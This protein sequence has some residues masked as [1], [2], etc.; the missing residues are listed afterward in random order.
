MIKGTTIKSGE[1]LDLV[2]YDDDL[3]A[4]IDPKIS[5]WGEVD[6]HRAHY[7]WTPFIQVGI[8]HNKY[9]NY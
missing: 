6:E 4:I 7:A 1:L 9:R 5:E 3:D 8:G 2:D